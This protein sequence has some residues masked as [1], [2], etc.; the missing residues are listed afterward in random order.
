MI[1]Y[2]ATKKNCTIVRVT[3]NLKRLRM[4]FPVLEDIADE[5]YHRAQS[6]T[7]RMVSMPGMENVGARKGSGAGEGDRGMAWSSFSSF[8][9]V[10]IWVGNERREE[11]TPEAARLSEENA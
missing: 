7:K 1:Q 11:T 4:T 5:A 3:G 9:H 10:G 2:S 8:P 6:D